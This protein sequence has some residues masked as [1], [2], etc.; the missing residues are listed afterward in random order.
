MAHA[1]NPRHRLLFGLA[2]VAALAMVFCAMTAYTYMVAFVQGN[3]A[4]AFDLLTWGVAAYMFYLVGKTW[5]S[6]PGRPS[7]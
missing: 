5:S 6:S 2:V 4:A 7:P 1:K 3:I